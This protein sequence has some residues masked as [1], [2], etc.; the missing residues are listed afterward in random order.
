MDYYNGA[1][2]LIESVDGAAVDGANLFLDLSYPQIAYLTIS[3]NLG[4]DSVTVDD[5][6]YTT[7]TPEPGSLVLLGSGLLGAAGILRRKFSC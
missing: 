2:N 3:A 6:S 7:G 4:A 5:V 1:G